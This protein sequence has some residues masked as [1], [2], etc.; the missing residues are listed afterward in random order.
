[1][2]DQFVTN[3]PMYRP[4]RDDD[5]GLDPGL[6]RVFMLAA[7]IGAA[8]LVLYGGYKLLHHGSGQIPVISPDPKPMRVRPENPGG[9][10]VAPEDTKA[11]AGETRLA[12]DTEEP[13]PRALN[14]RPDG[15]ARTTPPPSRLTAVTVQLSTAKTEAAAQTA[16]DKLAAKLPGLF[17]THRPLFLKTNEPAG[18]SWRL[19]TGGFTDVDQAKGFCEQVKAKGGTCTVN[20]P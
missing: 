12:P 6:I 9:M 13:D 1:M 17:G 20:E 10:R 16:W 3:G 18:A 7:G 15:A 11:A 14:M 4:S 5:Q 19:R 8:G 2:S